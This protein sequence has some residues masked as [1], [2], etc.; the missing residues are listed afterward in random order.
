[1][2]L[3]KEMWS[4]LAERMEPDESGVGGREAGWKVVERKCMEMGLRA[5]TREARRGERSG[6]QGED[7]GDGRDG[8]V[9]FGESDAEAE[10]QGQDSSEVVGS[11]HDSGIDLRDEE[12]DVRAQEIKTEH[13]T[14][15]LQAP[16]TP[17]R[18]YG[19]LRNQPHLIESAAASPNYVLEP[20]VKPTETPLRTPSRKVTIASLLRSP[21]PSPEPL[22]RVERWQVV[23]GGFVRA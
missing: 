17:S 20:V 7:E 1:M 12:G 10:G 4:L 13:V 9:E 2:V 15:E 3:R 16:V 23:G 22:P 11:L 8:D 19:Y 14:P 5:L 6:L 21:S 18:A